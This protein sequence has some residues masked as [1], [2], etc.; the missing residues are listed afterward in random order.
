MTN[1]HARR[2]RELWLPWAAFAVGALLWALAVKAELGAGYWYSDDSYFRYAPPASPRD[3]LAHLLTPVDSSG[4]YRPLAT[5]IFS[6]AS[7]L[8]SQTF[9]AYQWIVIALIILGG[10]MLA[11][12]TQ[13]LLRSPGA[14]ALAGLLYIF[15]PTH[16]KTLVWVTLLFQSAA[17]GFAAA[18]L[19]FRIH[20]HL[21][22]STRS[23][24]LSL[25]CWY[26]AIASNNGIHSFALTLLAVDFALHGG[27]WKQKLRASADHLALSLTVFAWIYVLNSPFR[28]TN[29]PLTDLL[30]PLPALGAFTDYIKVSLLH[31]LGDSAATDVNGAPFYERMM[32]PLVLLFA[33][34]LPRWGRRLAVIPFCL[35]GAGIVIA[36]HHH[37]WSVEYGLPLA[38]GTGMAAGAAFWLATGC[39]ARQTKALPLVALLALPF[40]LRE[41]F[42][43]E[44]RPFRDFFVREQKVMRTFTENLQRIDAELP[45]GRPILVRVAGTVMAEAPQLHYLNFSVNMD[46]ERRLVLFRPEDFHSGESL[47]WNNPAEPMIE[48][49]LKGA[50]P[51]LEVICTNEECRL[52]EKGGA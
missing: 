28:R 17:A 1:H 30:S 5:V 26:L 4:Y 36:L 42:L 51:P 8:P 3:M 35:A 32:G 27:S 43:W 31:Y 2:A 10:A 38:L 12:A 21:E 24:W 13:L 37:R 34:L 33:C 6:L 52:P 14:G 22:K 25:L 16:V 49:V 7:L 23:R 20:Y 48:A 18:A 40:L 46:F 19:A 39:G 41:K 44:Q 9:G 45:P 29:I 47:G 11:W 50:E 15:S